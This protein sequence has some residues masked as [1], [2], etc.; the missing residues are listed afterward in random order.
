MEYLIGERNLAPNTQ[1]SYRDTLRM[2]LPLA[3]REARKPIDR[4]EVIDLSN[5]RTRAFLLELEEKRK[6]AVWQRETS[7]SPKYTLWRVS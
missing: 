7:D 6:N 2:L 4:L 3:A 1:K 5:E